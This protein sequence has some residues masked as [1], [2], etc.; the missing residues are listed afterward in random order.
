MQLEPIRTVVKNPVNEITVCRDLER[1]T[2]VLYT[3]ISVTE[4]SVRRQLAALVAAGQFSATRDYQGSYTSGDALSLV[5]LYQPEQKLVTREPIVGTD[6]AHRRAIAMSLVAACAETQLGPSVG[7]LLLTDANINVTNDCGVYFNYFL[8]FSV[9]KPTASDQDRCA[10]AADRVFGVLAA[11]Y[12]QKYGA[13]LTQY[14]SELQ[15]LRKKNMNRGYR[16]LS[17]ILTDLRAMPPELSEPLTGW[18]KRLAQLGAGWDWVRRHGMALFLAV[19]VAV[20]LGYVVYQVT[21]RMGAR[22]AVE[23]N[24]SYIGLETIGSVYLGEENV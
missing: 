5:F 14:P 15:V 9:W 3:V 18:R 2:G 8:D 4:P 22:K 24:T 17:D 23:K 21:A 6:F 10:A 12:A 19:V 7:L 1:E 13:T 20:T 16:S 11:P